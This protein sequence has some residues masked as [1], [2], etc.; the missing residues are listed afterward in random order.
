MVALAM[1]L[2]PRLADAQGITVTGQV[3]SQSDES[4]IPGVNV[5]VKGASRGTTTASDGTYQ[6]TGLTSEST[7]VF[8]FIGFTKHEVTVGN[9]TKKLMFGW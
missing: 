6:L 8:S 1:L 4:S 2:L 9:R 7:L 3:V 5:T